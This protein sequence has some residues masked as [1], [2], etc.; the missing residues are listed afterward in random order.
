MS[1]LEKLEIAQDK[2]RMEKE[3]AAMQRRDDRINYAKTLLA[4]GEISQELHDKWVQRAHDEYQN[5][6]PSIIEKA[7]GFLKE[8]IQAAGENIAA[9]QKN[10][11]S[12]WDTM[13]E[14]FRNMKQESISLNLPKEPELNFTPPPSYM[15]LSALDVQKKV[16]YRRHTHK[17]KKK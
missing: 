8:R 14:N 6:P 9:S 3:R 11:P 5:P 16:V 12:L 4:A 13:G 15:D 17:K 1:L 2:A 7:G 10:Q